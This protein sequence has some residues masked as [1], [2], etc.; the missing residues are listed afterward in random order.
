MGECRLRGQ[1]HPRQAVALAGKVRHTQVP[2]V[3]AGH[4]HGADAQGGADPIAESFQGGDGFHVAG[5]R[6]D[7]SR[8]LQQPDWAR[9]LRRSKLQR[10]RFHDLRHTYASLL[11]AQG[12]RTRSTSRRSSA[13]PRSRRPWTATV[14]SCPRCTR[15]RRGSSTSSCSGIGGR[16]RTPPKT[17][18]VPRCAGVKMGTKREKG[19]AATDR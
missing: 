4:R 18:K 17:T 19:L 11:I 8:Q 2:P 10:I 7:G 3:T 5:G 9:V 6:G 1:P 16:S 14:T 13:T 15:R 12:R